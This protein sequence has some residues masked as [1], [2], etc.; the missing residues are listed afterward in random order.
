MTPF[1][2][3]KDMETKIDTHKRLP[4][5]L[6]KGHSLKYLFFDVDIVFN[7]IF[8]EILNKILNRSEFEKLYILR[9]D[10]VS[11]DP[12]GNDYCMFFGSLNS[13]NDY[14]SFLMRDLHPSAWFFSFGRYFVSSLESEWCIYCERNND[15]AILG[16]NPESKDNSYKNLSLSLNGEN[17]RDILN[18]EK[19]YFPFD[20]LPPEWREGFL[21]HYS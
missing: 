5:Q 18:M 11:I 9:V 20:D 17:I 1:D 13:G 2:F 7:E 6:F 15:F 3:V 12:H 4:D 16:G 8:F 10:Y 19:P 21:K 14:E